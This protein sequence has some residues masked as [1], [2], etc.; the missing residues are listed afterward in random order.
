MD[1][2][3]I[4]SIEKQVLYGYWLFIYDSLLVVYFVVLIGL[5]QEQL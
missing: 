2:L 1:L 4:L 3:G 5:F